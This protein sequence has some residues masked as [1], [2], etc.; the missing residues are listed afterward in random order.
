M[1][2]VL[3]RV[4]ITDFILLSV[5]TPNSC[6]AKVVS[7]KFAARSRMCAV[8]CETTKQ[9][10]NLSVHQDGGRPSTG[11]PEILAQKLT[12]L[13]SECH[14]SRNKYPQAASVVQQA[15]KVLC[16]IEKLAGCTLS[17]GR[18]ESSEWTCIVN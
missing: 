15:Y 6:L 5:F 4:A 8:M 16:D 2:R 14:A 1:K 9:A 17:K 3:D 11:I 7:V 10:V 18:G 12:L 13:K